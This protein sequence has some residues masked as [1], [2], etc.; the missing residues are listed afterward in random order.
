MRCRYK[1]ANHLALLQ[2]RK[3]SNA[4]VEGHPENIEYTKQLA[5]ARVALPGVASKLSGGYNLKDGIMD[6]HHALSG[7]LKVVDK[8]L[9]KFWIENAKVLLFSNSTKTL[10]LIE[11]YLKA[12]GKYV[13]L[14]MDGSTDSRQRQGMAD[15]FNNNLTKRK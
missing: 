15:E 7:K 5:F 14:R 13:Y 10:D 8:L 9:A 12:N 6:D 2:A 1:L 4:D 3:T 11:N